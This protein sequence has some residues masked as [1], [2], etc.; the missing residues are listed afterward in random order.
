[1][2]IAFPFSAKQLRTI[3][4]RLTSESFIFPDELEVLPSGQEEGIVMLPHATLDLSI[5]LVPWCS[6]YLWAAVQQLKCAVFLGQSLGILQPEP[7]SWC[8]F[9]E[10]F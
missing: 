6:F 4:N 1:M 10:L 2:A 8:S 3:V 9:I 7:V 5:L